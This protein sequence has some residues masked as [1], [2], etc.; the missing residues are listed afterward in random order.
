MHSSLSRTYHRRPAEIA[1]QLLTRWKRPTTKQ[2][3]FDCADLRFE[4]LRLVIFFGFALFRR[5]LLDFEVWVYVV[6]IRGVY[7]IIA[8]QKFVEVCLKVFDGR[9]EGFV[10]ALGN[11]RVSGG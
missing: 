9:F 4:L 8:I 1:N 5:R 3:A 10:G 7:E 2:R 11:A 6:V